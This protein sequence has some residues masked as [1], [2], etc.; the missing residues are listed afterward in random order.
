MKKIISIFLLS[1]ILLTAFSGCYEK[2][3]NDDS[4][5]KISVV[6]TGFAAY[7]FTKQIAGDLADIK[8]L[9]PP[10]TESHSFE[11]TPQDIITIQNCDIFIYVGGES[12]EWV[13]G[14]LES[15]DNSKMKVITLIDCVA[16]LEEEIVE[17][18][19]TEEDHDDD[20]AVDEHIWTSPQ[21]AKLIV[22]KITQTLC[23]VDPEHETEYI[24]KESFY[25]SELDKLD[26]SFREVVDQAVRK[27]IIFGDRFPFRYLTDAYGLEYYAAFPGCSTETEPSASTIAFLIDKIKETDIPVVFFVEL[28]NQKIANTICE[29]TSAKPLLLH[30]CHNISKNDFE[31][32]IT[33]LELMNDNILAL[34]EALL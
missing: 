12:D 28:S 20:V 15:I 34:K 7:D 10:A 11:P 3:K 29:E 17:G 9:L 26:K 27:V 16:V 14:I 32:G 4:N 18:M 22:K 21:N 6:S 31:K 24:R 19:S 2:D 30:S 1:A 23:E 8:M 13:A 5:G 33:Y 25:Q